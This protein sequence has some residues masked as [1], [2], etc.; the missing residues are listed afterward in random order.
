[1]I[2]TTLERLITIL[3]NTVTNSFFYIRLISLEHI[4]YVPECTDVTTDNTFHMYKTKDRNTP[5][6]N[7]PTY[8]KC[9]VCKN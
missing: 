7:C 8:I 9:V 5:Q 4:T 3:S 2:F 6:S 1:M